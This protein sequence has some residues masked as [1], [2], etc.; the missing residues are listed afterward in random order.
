V[1]PIPTDGAMSSSAS[2]P[3]GPEPDGREPDDAEAE[4][5]PSEAAADLLPRRIRRRTQV[6]SRPQARAADDATLDRLLN[7]LREI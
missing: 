2:A 6:P 3:A 7:G 5:P 4:L 1:K